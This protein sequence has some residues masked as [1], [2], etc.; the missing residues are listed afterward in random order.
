[1]V[2][3]GELRLQK[4]NF[5]IVKK[6]FMSYD[7]FCKEY[8]NFNG[9]ACFS[10]D[11]KMCG[12][13]E[14]WDVAL[15]LINNLP[16][17]NRIFN[18]KIMQN[19]KVKPYFDIEFMESLLETVPDTFKDIDQIK[20]HI[21]EMLKFIFTGFCEL[22]T[23]DIL[24]ATCHR[25]IPN[26]GKK[27]SFHIIINNGYVVISSRNA[28]HF[29]ELLKKKII[30]ELSSIVDLSV[31]KGTQNF[32][33]VGHCK[34]TDLKSPFLVETSTELCDFL[35]TNIGDDYRIMETPDPDDYDR[36]YR[37]KNISKIDFLEDS[38]AFKEIVQ[39]I[40]DYHPTSY[41]ERIDAKGFLQFNYHDR[42]E[43]CFTSDDLNPVTHDKLG[44][45]AYIT[46]NNDIC[47]A[48]HSARC[49]DLN[50][51]KIIKI[52][53]TKGSNQT[54]EFK[55]VCL[56]EKDFDLST[57]DIRN[58]IFNSAH[59]LA[60]LF[61]KMYRNPN[62]IK[63]IDE[64]RNGT[65]YF[66]NG[67]KWECDEMSFLE[68]LCVKTLVYVLRDFNNRSKMFSIEDQ[69]IVSEESES[70][71]LIKLSKALVKKLNDG[72]L[73]TNILKF[74]K[75]IINDPHFSTI[76]DIHPS[77]L[78]CKN[79]MVD[80]CSGNL[81]SAIPEDNITKTLDTQYDVNADSSIFDKFVKEI[82]SDI[83]GYNEEK[84]NYFRYLMGYALHG[85][86]VKKIFIILY[87]PY[88]NNGKSLVMSVINN[89]LQHYSVTMD[90]SVVLEGPQK[91]A[92]SH[93]TELV[94]LE[95]A[96]Y[97]I[98]NDTKE[99]DSINDGQIK[100]LTGVTDKMSIREIFGKQKEIKP[101]FVPIISTNHEINMN[102]SDKA[103]YNRLIIF[104]FVLRFTADP[105]EE[106]EKPID[107]EL[108]EKLEKNKTGTLKWLID[109]AIFYHQNRDYPV[110]NFVK[111]EKEKYNIQVNT[112]LN[113]IENN[114]ER[115]ENSFI[116]KSELLSLYKDY[117][118]ENRKTY[119]ASSAEKEFDNMLVVKN[120]DKKGNINLK[121][122]TK[123]YFG[124]LYINES[125]SDE[126]PDLLLK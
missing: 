48:C 107:T 3:E 74:A 7:K 112:Y 41:F 47:L 68:H 88:G 15:S 43:P 98:L 78:S 83:Q 75:P 40:L 6:T 39:R 42:D 108:P 11:Y 103:M 72:N 86:P 20:I 26:K 81:R 120:L 13:F 106:Y 66:W 12:S 4:E 61:C 121:G 84:Y 29:A 58:A 34:G 44:F 46:K 97:G 55:K 118:K 36:C 80:L 77:F 19:V 109:A 30:P 65:S 96:R 33:M 37:I 51:K 52:I 23:K 89:V 10:Y 56:D 60:E 114:F 91:T 32:R 53:G 5:K 94:A 125:D 116:L 59:G 49:E 67:A 82:T 99:G 113:F 123:A 50:N 122:K 79:G 87:G 22:E 76:K 71:D 90:K 28:R 62:R 95:H 8:K 2:T 110:P 27:Y 54:K 38:D 119:V 100:Q 124:I 102:L 115:N 31:Y 1:M 25:D 14:N 93:S 70:E 85:N 117:C 64:G 111:K 24:I 57:F 101:V 9:R 105:I 35:I 126:E 92:G 21:K 63:W 17:E 18:E 45:F 16:E 69:E 73:H 104:P